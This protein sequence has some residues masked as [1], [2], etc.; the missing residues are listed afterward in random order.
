MR[1][2]LKNSSKSNPTMSLYV[3]LVVLVGPTFVPITNTNC[4]SVSNIV[5]FLVIVLAIKELNVLM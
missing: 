1:L 4:L 2:P 3:F 5:F